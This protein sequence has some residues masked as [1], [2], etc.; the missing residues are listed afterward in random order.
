MAIVVGKIRKDFT[1]TSVYEE[2]ISVMLAFSHKKDAI[3]QM[4]LL[5]YKIIFKNWIVGWD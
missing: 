4:N 1:E 3:K 2:L 5:Q